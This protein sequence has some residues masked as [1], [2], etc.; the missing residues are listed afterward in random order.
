VVRKKVF[1]FA[2]AVIVPSVETLSTAN[3]D[4]LSLPMF[5]L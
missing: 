2:V 4:G 3:D 1:D 5:G